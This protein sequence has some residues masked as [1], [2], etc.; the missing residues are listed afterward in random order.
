MREGERGRERE[1]GEP[2][3][4]LQLE[5]GRGSVVIERERTI[6]FWLMN[7]LEYFVRRN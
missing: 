2:G 4:S 6:L 5:G 7:L 3:E 1:E